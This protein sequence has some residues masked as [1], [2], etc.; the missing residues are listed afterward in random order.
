MD[1]VGFFTWSI[2]CNLILCGLTVKY[3]WWRKDNHSWTYWLPS[4]LW[5]LSLNLGLW[6]YH[7]K[8]NGWILLGAVVL[9]LVMTL[10]TGILRGLIHAAIDIYGENF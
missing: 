9:W 5:A 8:D 2:G 10:A 4:L 6:L 1:V 7:V 3:D